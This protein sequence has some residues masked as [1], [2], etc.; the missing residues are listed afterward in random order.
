MTHDHLRYLK[1]F[2]CGLANLKWTATYVLSIAAIN[3][4]VGNVPLL[5]VFGIELPPGLLLAGAVFVLRDFSQQE[6]GHWVLAATAAASVLS[7]FTAG[8]D[9][10]AASTLA[11]VVSETVDWAVFTLTRR[12]LSQRILISS[13]IS[14]PIDTTV[15]YWARDIASPS[16]IALGIAVK[17]LASVGIWLWL[18]RR[19]QGQQSYGAPALP[20]WTTALSA[21]PR[22]RSSHRMIWVSF[23]RIGF[24][25]YPG[26]PATTAYLRPQHRHKFWFRVWIEVWH[27]DREI[28]F[29]A[30]LE[31]LESL[32]DRGRL[33]LNDQSCEA[34][35]DHLHQLISTAH[36]GRRVWI[37]VSEDGENGCFTTYEGC[38]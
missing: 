22:A 5:L 11:F 2:L 32:Y 21:T 14:V 1:L 12:R 37:E 18:R 19:E 31:W 16:G 24:H 38:R 36:P 23:S 8:F 34:I 27:D 13:A 15:F 30:F 4:S 10:A 9:I 25:A 26:A 20:W 17:M 7:Y 35:A 33:Q 29:H 3:W 28:E 6:I